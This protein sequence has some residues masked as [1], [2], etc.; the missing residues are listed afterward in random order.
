MVAMKK[1]L[2]SI[3]LTGALLTSTLASPAVAGE[4]PDGLCNGLVPTIIGTEGNDTIVG[5]YK[6]D[7]ILALGGDDTIVGNSGSDTICGG[8]GNDTIEGNSQSDI[9]FGGPGND[10]IRGNSDADVIYGGPGNDVLWGDSQSDTIYGGPGNDELNGG[11]DMDILDGGDGNDTVDGSWQTDI[12]SNAEDTT[13]CEIEG[14]AGSNAGLDDG[15]PKLLT[16]EKLSWSQGASDWVNLT[17]TADGE[18]ANVE[19]QLVELSDGLTVEYPSETSSSRLGVD[20]NLSK[21]EID[22]TAIKLTTTSSGTKR[23]VVEI[24][25]DDLSGERQT[26]SHKIRL[27]NKKYKGDDF[28]ILTEQASIGMDVEAPE[29]NWVDLDY[30]GI[31][32]SNSG[33]EMRVSSDLPVYHPQES[34]TSLHHDQLLR[35]GEADV[36][37]IWFDPELVTEGTYEVTVE[38]DYVDTNGNNQ[39]VSHAIKLAVG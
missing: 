16:N 36:A 9:I 37:R 5:T 32:P 25:W 11:S 29:A 20:S 27:T 2:S 22:F 19:V 35:A 14:F 31:A 15:K 17:W 7:V 12:C 4:T 26:S 24:S 34:F 38:I 13:S 10:K 23:A 21:S 3:V 18:L 33:M 6:A 28:A 39:T 8:E 30:K 1:P